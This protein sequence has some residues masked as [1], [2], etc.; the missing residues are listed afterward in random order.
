MVYKVNKIKKK[1]YSFIKW[2]TP[3]EVR[4]MTH[5]QVRSSYA[6]IIQSMRFYH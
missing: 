2:L 5:E 1:K 4:K 6:L 3:S